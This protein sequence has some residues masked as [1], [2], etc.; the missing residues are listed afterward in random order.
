MACID[1]NE[2]MS[3]VVASETN[4]NYYLIEKSS[5]AQHFEFAASVDAQKDE[6][7][8]KRYEW[9]DHN[10]NRTQITYYRLTEI[11]LDGKSQTFKML[12]SQCA[13]SVNLGIVARSNEQKSIWID[14]H[15][16]NGIYQI[17]VYDDLGRQ[18]FTE[19]V[20]IN[21]SHQLFKL[22][23]TPFEPALYLIKL[24]NAENTFACKV[25]VE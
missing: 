3:W 25:L 7:F 18:I 10:T 15:L 9:I 23:K 13:S 21:E 2:Q 8:P 22:N 19:W 6:Q 12:T 24:Q 5:D 1:Q 20:E 4:L 14:S 17:F 11:D 16:N